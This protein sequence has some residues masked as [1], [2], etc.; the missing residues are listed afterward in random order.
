ML[1]LAL[2]AWEIHQR[3]PCERLVATRD[4]PMNHMIA[5]GDWRDEDLGALACTAPSRAHF[6]GRYLTH[7]MREGATISDRDTSLEPVIQ[8]AKDQTQYW[9]RVPES[10]ALA[11]AEPGDR[12]DVCQGAA[13]PLPNLRAEAIRCF[14]LG[15]KPM[16]E[17]AVV[18][19]N[20]LIAQLQNV[21][22]G[23]YRFSFRK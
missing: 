4:L 15:S 20:S 9:V 23:S 11:E 13:C 22:G 6:V 10:V 17:V 21:E 12:F 5:D 2:G 14:S 19:P 8:V 3:G 1:L 16:C 7:P 18:I